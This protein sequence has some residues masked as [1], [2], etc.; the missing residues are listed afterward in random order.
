LTKVLFLTGVTAASALGSPPAAHGEPT[1]L[2]VDCRRSAGTIRPLHGVNSGPIQAGETLDLSLFYREAGV[3]LTRLHDCHWPSADVVDIHV[4]FPDFRA[5]PERPESY[6]F[7]RTDGYLRAIVACGSQIVFRLGESIEHTKDKYHVHP[8][9]DPAKWAAVCVGIVRHY[10]D[11]WARGFHHGIRYW[12]IWNEPENRPAMWTGTDAQYFALYSAAAKAIKAR[13]PA[14][15]VGGP[16]VG[17][18][19]SM[20]GAVLEPSAF[21]RA[22][23]D[24][25]RRDAAPLDFFSWHTYTADPREP[26]RRAV[27]VR[28]LLDREGFSRTESHLNEWNYLPGDDWGPMLGRPGLQRQRWF[29]RIGG[30]EGAAFTA[31]TLVLLQDAPLDAANFYSADIQGFGLFNEY[32][33]PKKSYYALRAFKLLADAPQRVAIQGVLPPG[34]VAAAG[35][36]RART[37]AV[38]LA[39]NPSP[40]DRTVR[41]RLENLPWSGPTRCEVLRLDPDHD[42]AA[43]TPRVLPAASPVVEEELGAHSVVVVK[44]QGV[45]N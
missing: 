13:C 25:C 18:L 5:D 7:R 43:G 45:P 29:E 1:E 40:T 11:G 19:G 21:V 35:L 32:G 23:L 30:C 2:T 9:A 24:H 16:A 8:P 31:A 37:R 44:L 28:R 41:L 26:A 17:Y 22:F 27:A 14:V 15:C 3:P 42:L 4:L 20:Q 38:I 33:V 34:V 39:V 6:D 36:D 10:N 12:E